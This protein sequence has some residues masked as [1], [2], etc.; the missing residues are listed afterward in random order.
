MTSPFMA[1]LGVA[2]YIYIVGFGLSETTFSLF[3]AVTS[4]FFLTGPLLHMRIGQRPIRKVF[5]VGYAVVLLV[6]LLMLTVAHAGPYAFVLS[7]IPFVMMSSY[8]RPFI[9]DRLLSMQKHDIG[10]AAAAMNFGFTV[11]GSI[12]M[13]T[14]SLRWGNYI[15]GLGFTM[16]IFLAASMA[17]SAVSLRTIPKD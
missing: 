13:M 9:S 2:S 12:G 1:Y 14:G 3:F 5:V 6:A 10:A 15:D 16:L 4:A 8:F 7:F 17:I 11:L